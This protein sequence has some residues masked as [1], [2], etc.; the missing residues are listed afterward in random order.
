MPFRGGREEMKAEEN[1]ERGGQE[2]V[3]DGRRGKSPH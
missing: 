2:K 1:P 3:E